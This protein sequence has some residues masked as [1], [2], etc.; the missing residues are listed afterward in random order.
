MKTQYVLHVYRAV[1]GQM[2]GRL[3]DGEEEVCGVAGCATVDEVRESIE[4]TGQRVDFVVDGVT[5]EGL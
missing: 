1:S 2:S 4:K 3:F 5:G